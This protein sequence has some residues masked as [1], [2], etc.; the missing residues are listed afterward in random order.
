[1]PEIRAPKISSRELERKFV[2][3]AGRFGWLPSQTGM[4]FE[5][6]LLSQQDELD[7][8]Y[9]TTQLYRH[10][11][12]GLAWQM[13]SG[14]WG[15]AGGRMP[16]GYALT[17]TWY[18]ATS[19]RN[20]VMSREIHRFAEALH[21]AEVDMVLRRGPAL[22]GHVYD[23]IGVRPMSDIDVLVRP[24]HEK[25]FM[26]AMK[27]LGY[28][29]GDISPDKTQILPAE[30]AGRALSRLLLETKDTVLPVLIV[31][32]GNSLLETDLASG[33][34]TEGIF[35][36]AVQEEHAEVGM[37]SVMAPHHL[38]LDL[39]THLYEESTTAAY[40]QRGRFQRIMQYVDLLALAARTDPP[41]ET[42]VSS[43]REYGLGAPVYFALEN[44]RRLY[45]DAPVP[46]EVTQRLAAEAEVAPGFLDSYGGDAE[47]KP[48]QW[49]MSVADR[50]FLE[51]LPIA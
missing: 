37:V 26:A 18:R 15:T 17:E 20:R 7:W 36:A 40:V 19:H 49:S 10:R 47:G 43:A 48:R 13:L 38:I 42:V 8:S 24:G 46:Q 45:S 30:H 39:C 32:P 28:R 14:P 3:E 16:R 34:D 11:L 25:R 41:W 12:L 27:E 2:L 33:L 22:I 21:A 23:D 31:D 50:M 35:Q 1:M 9:L 5:D 6:G 51:S 44:A 29:T 4:N